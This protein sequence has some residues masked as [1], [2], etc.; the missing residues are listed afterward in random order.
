M[1]ARKQEAG[2]SGNELSLGVVF[3]VLRGSTP[4]GFGI[5][6]QGVVVGDH[7]V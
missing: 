3:V 7:E 2:V 5:A 6:Y 1:T 4:Y